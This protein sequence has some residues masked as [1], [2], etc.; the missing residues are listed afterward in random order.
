MRARKR[1]SDLYSRCFSFLRGVQIRLRNLQVKALSWSAYSHLV[2]V[3][4]MP[5]V[6]IDRTRSPEDIRR[7]SALEANS[8]ITFIQQKC[9]I[10]RLFEPSFHSRLKSDALCGLRVQVSNENPIGE[11]KRHSA[12]LVFQWI[13]AA[14]A[15]PENPIARFDLSLRLPSSR[16][17]SELSACRSPG[18]GKRAR[19]IRL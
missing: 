16:D 4:Q 6:L 2:D 18:G 11:Q 10:G 12:S 3:C 15:S 13:H 7:Q 9:I 17:K 14:Q 5:V 1:P 8:T 19:R